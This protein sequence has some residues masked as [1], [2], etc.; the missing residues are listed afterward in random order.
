MDSPTVAHQL[1]GALRTGSR[2]RSPCSGE[3]QWG[4]RSDEQP[5]TILEM[6]LPRPQ[7]L[8]LATAR[9]RADPGPP[10]CTA[11][12]VVTRARGIWGR[13]GACE[14]SHSGSAPYAAHRPEPQSSPLG[15]LTAASGRVRQGRTRGFLSTND[16]EGHSGSWPETPREPARPRSSHTANLGWRELCYRGRLGLT[17][18]ALPSGSGRR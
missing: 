10:V 15:P 17:G 8:P 6:A 7:Q 3:G 18:S 1:A 14:A 12:R 9:R 13:H 11:G 16:L 2:A 4:R 5:Q